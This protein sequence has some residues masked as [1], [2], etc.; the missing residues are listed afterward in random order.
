MPSVDRLLV[1]RAVLVA[2]L[3]GAATVASAEER[4]KWELGIGSVFYTQ[5]DYIGSDEYRFRPIPF[6]WIIYRG[7]RLRLD[8]ESMQTRIFGTSLV[9]LDLSASGQIPVDS[10]DNDLRH[11]MPDLDWVAQVGPSLKF[12]VAES[13]DGRHGLDVDV[14][15]RAAFAVDFDH[16]S[17]E[18]LVASPKLVYR[19]E[20]EGWRFEGN[21]GLEFG[22][23]DYNEFLYSVAARYAT[24]DRPAYG[25]DG[26]YAGVRLSAGVSRYF[27]RFYVGL[28]SRY[29]NLEGATFR[30]SPLVGSRH[31]FFGGVAIGWIWMKS[32]E[33]VPVGAEANLLRRA[34][35][36]R[37]LDGV[38]PE[39]APREG[40]AREQDVA[41]VSSVPHAGGDAAA[42]SP[43]AVP[44][45]AVAP[46][47]EAK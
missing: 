36:R 35:V 24:P 23:N 1:G 15:L 8:R 18:G 19:F 3:F 39:S 13:D 10:D 17:Y 27:G 7:T 30:D 2:A 9:R 25:A 43:S 29:F 16:F 26:G 44:A 33:M 42:G 21:A 32:D 47:D 45:A 37:A 5:P 34:A 46:S 6:P 22:N 12:E 38:P 31:A 40:S 11:G 28:F 41:P 4:P 20:P 14:P